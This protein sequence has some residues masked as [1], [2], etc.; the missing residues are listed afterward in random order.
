MHTNNYQHL[1]T[2][3]IV[4]F[5]NENTVTVCIQF[6]T[7]LL[8]ERTVIRTAQLYRGGNVTHS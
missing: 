7:W 2:W 6:T 1:V 5:R 3:F 8:K 4:S